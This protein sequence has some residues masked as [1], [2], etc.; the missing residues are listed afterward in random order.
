MEAKIVLGGVLDIVSKGE[1]DE[2]VDRMLDFM[3]KQETPKPMFNTI[4]HS[5]P[6]TN[7]FTGIIDVGSPPT[8]RAW[9]VLG[10]S[11]CGND[12][13]TVSSAGVV[14]FYIGA[15]TAGGQPSL[16]QLRVPRLTLPASQSF[17]KGTHWCG[18]Q[19][20]LMFNCVALATPTQFVANVFVAEWR[21][22]DVFDSLTR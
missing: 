9:N 18:A 13:N 17:T 19:D 12:D 8:G 20:N 5:Q 7:P 21:E 10:F 15:V 22:C 1:L 4:T 3:G 14:G 16:A 2:G 6:I 11:I